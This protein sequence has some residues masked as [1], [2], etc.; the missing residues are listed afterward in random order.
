MVARLD[1]N[2]SSQKVQT[3]LARS[4]DQSNRISERLSSGSQVNRPSDDA[5]GLAISASLR[6]QGPERGML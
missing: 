5:A 6:A 3:Q 4:T 2:L 1:T